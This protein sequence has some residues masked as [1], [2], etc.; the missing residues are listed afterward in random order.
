MNIER[1]VRAST[2]V[3]A[4]LLLSCS[5]ARAQSCF[6][7]TI[8]TPSPF[9]GNHG[10]I[11]KAANGALYEVNASYEYLYAYSPQVVICPRY[12]KMLVA[13]KTVHIMPLEVRPKV[14]SRSVKRRETELADEPS[15][16]APIE[17]LFRVR[18]CDYFL[19]DGPRG[20][21]LLEWYGGYDPLLH[22]GISGDLGNYGFKDVLYSNGRN[23]RV[24]VDDYM[25]SKSRAVEKI[26]EKCR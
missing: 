23:G 25:L 13:G 21:Y 17:I 20:W 24:Y 11:F 9:M 8:V 10:E 14:A 7:T 6:E 15:E 19:A 12:G 2:L 22:D 16:S 4:G 3:L 1:I 5:C 26:N 18:G